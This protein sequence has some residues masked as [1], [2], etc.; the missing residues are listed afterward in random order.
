MPHHDEVEFAALTAAQVKQVAK[1]EKKLGV[2]ILAYRT[3]LRPAP[4]TDQQ[5]AELQKAEA[6]M[7]G[8]CLVAYKAPGATGS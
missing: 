1:L 6:A 4:L 2:V 3:P 8:V 7:P 5:V